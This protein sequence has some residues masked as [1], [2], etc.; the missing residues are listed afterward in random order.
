MDVSQDADNPRILIYPM[1]LHAQIKSKI[2]EQIHDKGRNTIEKENKNKHRT[3]GGWEV[4]EKERKKNTPSIFLVGS[5][6]GRLLRLWKNN[7]RNS[8]RGLPVSEIA[9][10]VRHFKLQ[11]VAQ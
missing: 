10:F 1:A 11:P 9:N 3:A 2:E 5:Y 8:F 6:L 7:L 4:E